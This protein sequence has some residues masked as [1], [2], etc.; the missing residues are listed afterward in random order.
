MIT[1]NTTENLTLPAERNTALES[2]CA[3][4]RG[5]AAHRELEKT[6]KLQNTSK[7]LTTKY[8]QLDNAKL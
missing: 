8:P 1:T 3:T 7:K 6:K 5:G 4:F 2:G